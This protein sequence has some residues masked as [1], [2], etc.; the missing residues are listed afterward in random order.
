MT[1]VMVLLGFLFLKT[2]EKFATQETAGPVVTEFMTTLAQPLSVKFAPWVGNDPARAVEYVTAKKPSFGIV[3][4]GFYLAYAKALEMKPWMEVRRTGVG[5]ERYVAVMR[6]DAGEGVEALRGK[7]VATTLAAEERFVRGVVLEDKLAEMRLKSVTDPEVAAFDV[8]E[9]GEAVLLE[10]AT[11][12][13]LA[14]DEELGPKLKVVFRSA[15]LPG[16]LFVCFGQ[17]KLVEEKVKAVLKGLDAAVTG[18]IR[19]EKFVDVNEERLK[20]AEARFHGK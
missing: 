13:A 20:Q 5:A 14:K 9:N 17:E 11:W 3:T 12:T 1:A 15:E 6:K 16:P 7:V 8:V 2:G 18:K 10:E 4:P 19:V